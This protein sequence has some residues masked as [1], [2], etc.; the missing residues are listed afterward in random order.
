MTGSVVVL[1]TADGAAQEPRTQRITPTTTRMMPMVTST[2]RL[3]T[4]NPTTTRTIPRMI[5]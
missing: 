4:S 2:E 5:I 1:A 3:F